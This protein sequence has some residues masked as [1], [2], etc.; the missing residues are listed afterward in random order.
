MRKMR[1]CCISNSDNVSDVHHAFQIESSPLKTP[2][3]TAR[4][5]TALPEL[6]DNN[7]NDHSGRTPTPTAKTQSNSNQS[8]LETSDASNRHDFIL[9]GLYFF[10]R[11]LL[12]FTCYFLIIIACLYS[13]GSIV[14]LEVLSFFC[15]IYSESFIRSYNLE[16]ENEY[17][18]DELGC[19]YI[20]RTRLNYN[21]IF[22]LD[23]NI[24]EANV[25]NFSFSMMIQSIL[26]ALTGIVLFVP[27]VYHSY[28]L[29]YDTFYAI[30]SK[31]CINSDNNNNTIDSA[32]NANAIIKDYNPRI[33]EKLLKLSQKYKK[34][35][36]RRFGFKA[37]SPVAKSPSKSTGLTTNS[38]SGQIQVIGD[39]F[40][41]SYI[42]IKGLFEKC[43]GFYE[44]YIVPIYYVDS[45]WR[46]LSLICREWFEII[47]QFYALLLYGGI[48]LISLDSKELSQTPEVIEAFTIIIGTNCIA[49]MY[50]ISV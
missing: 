39:C 16:N 18:D 30:Y 4:N 2:D 17:G 47:V 11:Y 21:A 29:I 31:F 49:C 35:H 13:I 41:Q 25:D 44:Q 45:K 33:D 19:Y 43:E 14:S 28:L 10:G 26:Y 5:V 38:K 42:K 50:T 40:L 48:N 1:Q 15:P 32:S 36:A 34:M 37:A 20:D 46:L 9:Y 8:T 7:T 6:D 12:L 23:L 24:F 22:E 27:T 3:S